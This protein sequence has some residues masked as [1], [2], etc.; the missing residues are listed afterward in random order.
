MLRAAVLLVLAVSTSC[1][2]AKG[3]AHPELF[4]E[5]TVFDKSM[6]PMGVAAEAT[7]PGV[8]EGMQFWNTVA[9]CEVFRRAETFDARVYVVAG[10]DALM[11][12]G[13]TQCSAK[14]QHCLVTI[15]GYGLQTPVISKWVV[16]HELGHALG[17]GHVPERRSI[18]HPT[19]APWAAAGMDVVPAVSM[20]QREA[21]RARYCK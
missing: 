1:H 8:V 19:V 2:M 17:L 13:L 10:V 21:I 16:A 4:Q 9:G 12:A 11:L 14:A 20:E 5:W 15:F 3:P 18:M 6:A 7:V